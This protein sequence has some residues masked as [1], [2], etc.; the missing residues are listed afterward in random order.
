MAKVIALIFHNI[1]VTFFSV[2]RYTNIDKL[3]EVNMKSKWVLIGLVITVLLTIT[4][5]SSP[6]KQVSVDEA[7]SGKQVEIAVNGSLTVT[8]ESNITTG[9]SWELKEIS[10][11]TVLQKTDNKYVAPTSDLIGAGGRDV[12]N[13]KTL[14]AGKT[15]LSMEY[16]QPWA[17]GQKSAQSF[18][19]T[20]IVK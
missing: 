9:Y 16:S 4:A 15:T 3:R 12:W 13:F 10:D 20:I 7:S 5:C 8:L 2:K 18:T 1:G 6:V 19:L 14:K 11:T 17:G